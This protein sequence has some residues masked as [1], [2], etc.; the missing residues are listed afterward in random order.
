[1]P[2]AVRNFKQSQHGDELLK[3]YPP[4]SS[5]VLQSTLWKTYE[6]K[7]FELFD[8]RRPELWNKYREYLKEYYRIMGLK[9]KYPPENV[10]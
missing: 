5:I 6:K 2:S 9:T 7:L 3:E 8:L 4:K 10:C 1:L